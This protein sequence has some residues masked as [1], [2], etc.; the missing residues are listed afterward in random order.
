MFQRAVSA[1]F[2]LFVSLRIAIRWW[3][4]Y[5]AVT[6]QQW[7]N[8]LLQLYADIQRF[9]SETIWNISTFSLIFFAIFWLFS[10]AFKWIIYQQKREIRNRYITKPPNNHTSPRK[11]KKNPMIFDFTWERAVFVCFFRRDHDG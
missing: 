2:C 6:K 1:V 3:W 8:T 5:D 7:T 10:Y 11:Q 4:C 9:Q